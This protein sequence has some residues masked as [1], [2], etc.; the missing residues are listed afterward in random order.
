METYNVRIRLNDIQEQVHQKNLISPQVAK[1][2]YIP[3]SLF[4]LLGV[5]HLT[6]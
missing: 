1:G 5:K 3:E 6:P 4:Y 2:D